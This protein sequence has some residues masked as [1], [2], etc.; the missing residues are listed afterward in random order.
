MGTGIRIYMGHGSSMTEVFVGFISGVDFVYNVYD[1]DSNGIR[2]TA[3]DVKG[4]MMA[5]NSSK[6]LKANYYSDAVKEILDQTP[7]QTLKNNNGIVSITISDT[8]DKP[9][10]GAGGTNVDNRLEM[11]AESDY[12]FVVKAARKFNFEFFSIGGNIVFRKAKANTQELGQIVP[13]HSIIS[14]D[15]GYDITGVVGEV[16]VRTLDIGK[17]SKIE[18]KKK[19]SNK[20]SLGSKAKALIKNQS[21]VYIDSAIESQQDAENRANYILEETSYRLGTLTMTLKG[22]PEFVPGRFIV[23]KDFGDGASNKFYLTDVIHEFD[24]YR[25]TTSIIGKASTL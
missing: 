16:K 13:H 5:N 3:L 1:E 14:Y 17:A 25:Y 18:V 15:I 7:Y 12:E 22:I 10:G 6:R 19:N 8:P 20:F 9:P 2:I 11:V 21:Y 4:I 23:L 24:G